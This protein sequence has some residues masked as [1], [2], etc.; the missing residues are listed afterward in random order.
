MALVLNE[1]RRELAIIA[2][3]LAMVAIV[4]N[5]GLQLIDLDDG[6][7]TTWSMFLASSMARTASRA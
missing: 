4:P 7:M 3:R 1:V 5:A 6:N 2:V